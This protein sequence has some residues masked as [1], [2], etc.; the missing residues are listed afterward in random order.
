MSFIIMV[1]IISVVIVPQYITFYYIYI[2]GRTYQNRSIKIN[3]KLQPGKIKIKSH[4][5]LKA[6]AIGADF[7]KVVL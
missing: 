5:L 6:S 3:D 2:F 7:L 4:Q 1:I